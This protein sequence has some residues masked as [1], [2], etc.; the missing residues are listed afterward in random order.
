LQTK[1]Q[2]LM[3]ITIGLQQIQNTLHQTSAFR[4]NTVTRAKH[5]WAAANLKVATT[6]GITAVAAKVLMGIL[7]FGLSAAIGVVIAVTDKLISKQREQKKEQNQLTESIATNSASQIANYEKLRVSYNRLGDDVKIK[8]KFITDNQ[9][10]FKQLGVSINTVNDADSAFIQNTNAF[11]E[12]IRQRAI[13]TAAM[14]LASEQYKKMLEEREKV[15]AKVDEAAAKSISRME[16]GAKIETGVVASDN[17]RIQPQL[18]LDPVIQPVNQSKAD[19]DMDI[20][21]SDAERKYAK[22]GDKWIEKSTSASEAEMS[23]LKALGLA[24][25]ETTKTKTLKVK[26]DPAIKAGERLSKIS[27]DIQKEIDSAIVASMREGRDK[28][29]A[30]LENEYNQRMRLIADRQ[31]EIKKLESDA[32]VDGSAQSAQLDALASAEKMKYEAAV[33]AV[34]EG[35]ASAIDGIWSE[36]N[37]RF[38]TESESR[39]SEIDKF[40]NQQIALARENGA[41][42]IEI[43]NIAAAHKR[44]IELEKHH[45]SL[46]TLDFE[47]QIQLRRAQI[48]DRSI[49]LESE[50]EEKI[51]KIQI[52]G[53]QKR[54]K[55]LQEIKDS[56]G[57]VDNEIAQVTA[58]ISA[59]NAE[60][61]NMP[62]KKFQELAGYAQQVLDGIGSF[63]SNFD[64][65]LGGLFDIASGAVGGIATLGA[66]IASG[67]P[68]AIIDGAM[69]LLEVTGK[70]I[71]ANKQA[72]EEIRKFNLGLAQQAIDYSL[73]VI[74]S[75]KDIKSETD[76]IF[77][78]DYTNTLNR[79]MEGYNAALAKQSELMRMLSSE[80]VKT[81]V[82][83]KKFL[84]MTYGT[85]DIYSS[86][87][88]TYPELIN[89]DG[90]L[91][92]ELAESLQKSGNLKEETSQLI[93]NILQASDAANEA[94]QSVESELQNLVGSIGVELKKALDNG[95]AS[96][97]D[98]A[99]AMTDSVVDMLKELSTQRLFNIVFGGLFSELDKRMKD[100]FDGGDMDLTD[101]INWFMKEYVSGVDQYNEGLEQLRKVIMDQYGVDPFAGAAE[102]LGRQATAQSLQSVTQDS[103]DEFSGRVTYIVM[104]ITTIADTLN[105]NYDV[106]REQ[107]F[108][109]QSMEGYLQTIAENSFFLQRLG[110][111]DEN[112]ERIVR[113]GINLKK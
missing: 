88:K 109:M 103:F 57:D 19:E 70:I 75:I 110:E 7:T 39:L 80:T 77:T 24:P 58:E 6:L 43:E 104:R 55:K 86:L 107:L 26:E 71:Q 111:I 10:A 18:Q 100:S 20:Y 36:I 82:E 38:A 53:A 3:A 22:A 108:L 12:A 91:N 34:N 8:E 87:L 72:N 16:A 61:D 33:S 89:K 4:I 48:A 69:R 23:I 30:E 84:G 25:T 11:K 15:Q 78:S 50:K 9:D 106:N 29:L 41:T 59:M 28:K 95:F 51:L 79:G 66:G 99:R 102:A 73:A 32:G 97:T 98:S 56:G 49:M 13:A 47:N 31:E 74:R 90:E 63:A 54:L 46:E 83:K 42:Q 44:D 21:L 68:K 5:L 112:I 76:S 67:D 65:D 93:D 101:D 105:S 17:T 113:E 1:V 14:E 92:R 27:A 62:V 94:M 45:L 81:G 52:D 85:K 60:L 64:E 35:S 37:S 96:G 2:S 40:Y